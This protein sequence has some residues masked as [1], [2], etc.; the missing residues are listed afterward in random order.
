MNRDE[1]F[2][3]V[4]DALDDAARKQ[5]PEPPASPSNMMFEQLDAP[6]TYTTYAVENA[7]VLGDDAF[8]AAMSGTSATPARATPLPPPSPTTSPATPDAAFD[9]ALTDVE[10]AEAADATQSDVDRAEADSAFSR[11]IDLQEAVKMLDNAVASAAPTPPSLA[12]AFRD[13]MEKYAANVGF[14]L[15][16]VPIQKARDWQ[17]DFGPVSG[18]A[19]EETVIT[20]SPQCLFRGE[21]VN[22]TDTGSPVGTGTRIVSVM[23]G[24]RIQK[25]TGDRTSTLT[26]FF[27][28]NALANGIKWDTCQRSNRIQVTVR[29]VQACTFDLSVFGKAVL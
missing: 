19:G 17:L 3:R 29:F 21:R 24:Q 4:L 26:A 10:S 20:V 6:A 25:L 8:T 14:T 28:A 11:A 7:E 5:A 16:K 13:F 12:S 2:A 15:R 1:V 18:P 9:A 23:V 22:A 27:A